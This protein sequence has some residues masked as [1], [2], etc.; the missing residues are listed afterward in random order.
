MPGVDSI[1]SLAISL[2]GE[3]QAECRDV[4]IGEDALLFSTHHDVGVDFKY[5]QE[6]NA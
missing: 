2:E 5:A 3:E 6:A 1:V 4:P